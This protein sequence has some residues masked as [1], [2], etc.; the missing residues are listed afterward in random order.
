MV[1]LFWTIV[2]LRW[3]RLRSSPAGKSVQPNLPTRD[4]FDYRARKNAT[5]ALHRAGALMSGLM[6]PLQPSRE[7]LLLICCR[8]SEASFIDQSAIVSRGWPCG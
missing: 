1:F 5:F 2:T 7:V 4:A 3:V 8:C 6:I